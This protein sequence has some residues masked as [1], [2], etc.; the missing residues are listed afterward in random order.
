MK[1]T[2]NSKNKTNVMGGQRNLPPTMKTAPT[3]QQVHTFSAGSSS[4]HQQSWW[5][6]LRFSE[7]VLIPLR[8]FLGIT[9]VYAG[10]QKLTDPQFFNPSATG[11]IGKQIMAFAH[12]SPIHNILLHVALP[13]AVFFGALIAVGEIAIGIGTLV[14]FLFR[15]AAF[16]GMLLSLM[17]FLSA[18]WHVYPYFYGADIAFF[19]AWTPLLLAGPLGSGL[20]S[21][22]AVLVPRILMDMTPEWR[23][24]I[25][26]VFNFLLGVGDVVEKQNVPLEEMPTQAVNK[27]NGQ[28]AQYTSKVS[29]YPQGVPQHIMSS[30]GRSGNVYGNS[31]QQ[32]QVNY[33][34]RNASIRRSQENRRNFLWGLVAGGLG[35]LGITVAGR[36]I[37][38]QPF[39][40]DDNASTITQ[41]PSTVSGTQ[42]NPGSGTATITASGSTEIAQVSAVQPNSSVTFTIPSNGDP[43]VLVRL[44]N[45]KFVAFDATC[46][47]AGCPVQYDPS[48]QH[49]LCPCH[50]AEFDPSNAAAV[51]QGPTSTPLTSVPINVN[52]STG[53]ITLQ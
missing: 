19:F 51:V 23:G 20:P 38:S 37:L 10:I 7:R 47:H 17:F 52:N 8:L 28:G 30:Q 16:F 41:S 13:H 45:G 49:L 34:G 21:I 14:G 18:S 46:T 29:G 11:F 12:G 2:N 24:R 50:G 27:I 15:P 53:A 35:M 32:K 1:Q 48:S 39:G 42:S 43:G 6:E 25:G 33:K 3:S 9:F 4:A 26:P 36:V 22:D 40:G 44:N 31:Q 5:K